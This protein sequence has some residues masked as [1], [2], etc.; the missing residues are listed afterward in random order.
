MLGGPSD[1]VPRGR[2]DFQ[3]FLEAQ[4]PNR[5]LERRRNVAKRARNAR[6][7]DLGNDEG[8]NDAQREE[9]HALLH[10]AHHSTKWALTSAETARTAT[11][12]IRA[13]L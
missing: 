8:H 9:D 5:S 1:Q 11:R 6:H 12:G 3:P 7:D 13:R 2:R 10:R 4:A